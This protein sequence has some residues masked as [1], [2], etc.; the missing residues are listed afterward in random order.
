MVARYRQGNRKQ[1]EKLSHLSVHIHSN[2]Q[3]LSWPWSSGPWSR[4]HVDFAGPTENQMILVVIDGYS[5]WIEAFPMPS[6]TSFN[7]IQHLK[8]LFAQFGIPDI[9][10]SDNGTSFV[11]QFLVRYGFTH[12]T[13]VPYHPATNGQAERAVQIVKQGLKK[14]KSGS[15][16]N[17]LAEILSRYQITPHSTTSET[18]AKLLMGRDLKSVLDLVKPNLTQKVTTQQQTQEKRNGNE[19]SKWVTRYTFEILDHVFL[20][21]EVKSF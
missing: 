2:Q 19:S 3:C 13:S 21:W 6:S 7:T 14:V 10:V 17:P 18:P 4:I 11:V 1:G 20:G 8:T 12:I 15:M 5:K 9:L 16:A